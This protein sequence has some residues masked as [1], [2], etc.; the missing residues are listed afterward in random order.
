MQNKLYCDSNEKPRPVSPELF[1]FHNVKG[2]LRPLPLLPFRF[3]AGHDRNFALMVMI[4][5]A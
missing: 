1:H 3:V 4:R 2:I 5:H